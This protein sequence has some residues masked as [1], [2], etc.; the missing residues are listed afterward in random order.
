MHVI[1]IYRSRAY[2]GGISTSV[3]AWE[4]GVALKCC[5]GP[6]FQEFIFTTDASNTSYQHESAVSI[7][8]Y[9]DFKYTIIDSVLNFT[10]T[11]TL[12]C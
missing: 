1:Y 2:T 12:K 9:L 8:Y 4:F 11:A 3:D 6:F 10:R 7:V 5:R